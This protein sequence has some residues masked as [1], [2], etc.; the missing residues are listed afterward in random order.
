MAAQLLG[1]RLDLPGRDALHLHLDQR[2]HERLLAAL[3]ALEELRG[4]PALPVLRHTQFHRAHTGHQAAWVMAAA[5]ALPGFATL[6]LGGT[7]RVGISASR[8]SCSSHC[9]SGC[10][11]S[12]FWLCTIRALRSG[13]FC[14]SFHE[15]HGG[16]FGFGLL[17]RSRS[18][19]DPLPFCRTFRTLLN[20]PADGSDR[21]QIY[22]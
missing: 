17:G 21:N 1:D 15:G 8:T 14:L 3:I 22:A 9:T 13:A 7:E 10:M 18:Y 19:H 12:W 16:P 4:K 20:A 11:K 2:R 5:V 6:A